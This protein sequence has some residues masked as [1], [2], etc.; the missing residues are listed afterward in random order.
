M[1]RAKQKGTA[2]ESA[3][4]EYERAFFDDTEQTIGR[5]TL[6]GVN[7]VG[8]IRGIFANGKRVVIECKNCKSY[9]LKEWLRQAERERA[10]A[11]AEY[12]VV[13][14]HLNGVGI[15]NMGEQAVL[16]TVDTFNKLIGDK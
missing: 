16:M 3:F 14:F 7:D 13:V 6:H 15:A 10:N 5:L 8:D 12:G 4:V 11:D 1:S 2:F 9:Q